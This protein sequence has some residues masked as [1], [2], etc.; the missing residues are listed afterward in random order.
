MRC[1]R[2][3]GAAA[4]TTGRH[5]VTC[6]QFILCLISLS[7]PCLVATSAGAQDEIRLKAVI[8]AAGRHLPVGKPVWID[9]TLQNL[10]PE[11][12]TLTVPGTESE[13]TDAAMGLPLSHVFSGRAFAGLTVEGNHGRRWDVA[14]DYQPPGI[15]ELV[16]IAPYGSVG[17]SLE[18]TRYYPVLQTP[19][20]Y[21]LSWKPYG[22]ALCSNEL[23]IEVAPRKQAILLTDHGEM[24]IKLF[25]DEAPNHVENFL[26]LAQS[27]FYDNL[28]FHKILQGTFIQG[29]C[30]VGNGTGIRPDGKKLTAEFNSLP[31]DRGAVNM[32]RL[33]T[34]PDSAS[35]QFFIVNTRVPEW[36][37]RY[38]IF[39]HLT[40]DSSYETLDKLMA[41]PV[42]DQGLFPKRVYLRG[43]RIE[44]VRSAGPP[45][46]L[47]NPL[48][49]T[50]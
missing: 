11:M 20:R 4:D 28:T 50:R 30:P 6:R 26:G 38:T 15:T 45:A 3:S 40:G 44:D 7:T 47:L 19:G 22:A 33:E 9:F 13:R 17:I 16:E 10:S 35:C 46:A 37:G 24:T 32:A 48:G 2:R 49:P 36:D 21:R 41:V 14:M 27:G 39:G 43:V 34:D 42:D 29:G 18:V 8:S 25:Y 23:M 1:P 5:D 31:Q 12:V